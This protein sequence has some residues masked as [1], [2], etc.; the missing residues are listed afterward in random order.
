MDAGRLKPAAHESKFE[1]KGNAS[2]S[3]KAD[4]PVRQG[5]GTELRTVFEYWILRLRGVCPSLFCVEIPK[6]IRR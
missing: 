1:L 4:D 2:S 3:A 6:Q 5:A